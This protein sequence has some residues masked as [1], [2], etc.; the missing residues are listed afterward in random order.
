MN[1]DILTTLSN[2]LSKE[3]PGN[4]AHKQI[5]SYS[6]PS[7][8]IVESLGITPKQSAVLI[9]LYKH[10]NKICFPLIVRPEYN[11]VH[12]RQIGLPGG[13]KEKE[14]VSLISTAIRETQEEIGAIEDNIT[15]LGSL[16]EIYIPP[17]NFIVKPVIGYYEPHSEFIPDKHEVSRI[18]TSSLDQLINMEVVKSKLFIREDNF[19]TEVSS[20]IIENEI[21]WGATAMILKELQHLLQQ[22]DFN[23][24]F[25]QQ[26]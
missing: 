12:S 10:N 21:V 3:L 18:I 5:Y 17:S 2:A 16:S 24:F 19:K 11:G 8:E 20:Y 14:D 26:P 23:E 22:H 7:V 25:N 1:K 9:L 15:V 6:R 13:K 4:V